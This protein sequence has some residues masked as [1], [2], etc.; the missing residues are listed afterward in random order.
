MTKVIK[1]PLTLPAAYDT[2]KESYAL[3]ASHPD[4]VWVAC[5]FLGGWYAAGD[6]RQLRFLYL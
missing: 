2:K 1:K 5:F 3:G 4:S 6:D